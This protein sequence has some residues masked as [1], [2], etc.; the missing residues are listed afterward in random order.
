MKE[1]FGNVGVF[2]RRNKMGT[3]QRTHSFHIYCWNR[4][5]F[6]PI[7][8]TTRT[9]FNHTLLRCIWSDFSWM[10]LT[11]FIKYDWGFGW[12]NNNE[13]CYKEV[14][15]ELPPPFFGE[16]NK[17]SPKRKFLVEKSSTWCT[18][19]CNWR[20]HPVTR[21]RTGAFCSDIKQEIL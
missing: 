6:W 19:W 12:T 14:Q 9:P 7:W 10:L 18:Q 15:S 2:G 3:W 8:K 17:A 21:L 5:K 11:L 16:A 13:L 4:D 1:K 20:I